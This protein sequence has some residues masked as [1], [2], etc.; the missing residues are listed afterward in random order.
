[1]GVSDPVILQWSVCPIGKPETLL[2]GVTLP[3]FWGGEAGVED[4]APDK[5]S[6]MET[7]ASSRPSL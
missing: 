5:Q 6:R 4:M 3:F 2:L 1:M 7:P